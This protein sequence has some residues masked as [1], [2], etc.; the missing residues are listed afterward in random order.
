MLIKF[1]YTSWSHSNPRIN[2]SSTEVKENIKKK[3]PKTFIDYLQAIDDLH[4]S[5]EDQNPTKEKTS[6]NSIW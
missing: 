1:Y 4:E 3:N 5:L 6:A 2:Y